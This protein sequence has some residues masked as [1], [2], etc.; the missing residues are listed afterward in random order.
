MRICIHLEFIE[1]G[2]SMNDWQ[3]H[4]QAD[5]AEQ[6]EQYLFA[7]AQAERNGTPH[8]VVELLAYG[9]G[10]GDLYKTQPERKLTCHALTK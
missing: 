8:E 7:L 2:T 10:V 1:M 4:Q 9:C 5:D 3:Q 6:I